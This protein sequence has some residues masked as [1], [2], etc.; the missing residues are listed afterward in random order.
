MGSTSESVVSV[1]PP[2]VRE[3]PCSS[4]PSDL[5]GHVGQLGVLLGKW[6]DVNSH[7]RV[8][9]EQS[10]PSKHPS[11][12]EVFPLPMLPGGLPPEEHIWLQAAIRALNW[13]ACGDLTLGE[14][15]ASRVQESLLTVLR[16]SFR[17]ERLGSHVFDSIPMEDYW[18]SKGVNGYGEEVHSALPFN[19][20][21]IEHSLP[22]REQ[23]GALD[24]VDVASAGIKDFLSDPCKYLKPSPSRTWMKPPRVMVRPEDWGAVAEG[25]VERR[26]CEVIPLSEVIRVEGKPIL[27][28]LF[29]VPKNEEIGGVPVLR[30]IMDLRPINQLFESI[31][32][33]LH[34]LPMLSQL[35][36]L[37]IFP[38]EDVLV[39]SEDIKAMFYIV[40][41]PSE[42]RPLLA[43]GREVP[44]HLRPAGVNEPC[45]LTSRVLPMG[46]INSVSVAQSLHRSIVNRAVDELGISRDK[47]IRRDQSL[48]I[49]ALSYRVYLDNFDSL[50]RTN[51]EAASLLEGSLSPLAAELR[52]VYGK[53]D[54]P[55]NEKKSNRSARQ[56]EMQGGWIDG[57]EGTI[58]PKPDKFARYLRAC[59]Y[60]L[61]SKTSNLKRIQVVAGGLVYLFSYRRCLMS[62][63]NEVW[64]FISSFEG[65]VSVWKAIP[66]VVKK[67]LFCC[68]ALA[69]LSY[70]DLRLPFDALVSASDASE[71][72]GGLS[73]STGVTDMGVQAAGKLVR[74]SYGLACDDVQLLVISLFDGIAACRVALDVLGAQVGAY[75]AV[76]ADPC[77]KRV[78]ESAFA[79]VEFVNTVD[80]VT[81]EIVLSWARRFSRVGVVLISGGP[82]CQG[83][84]GLGA[85]KRGSESASNCRL[86]QEV[87]R[88]RD[89]AEKHF[90]WAKVF[91]LM[92]SVSSMSDGDLASVTR[93]AGILPYELD[94]CGLTPC[95][96]NRLFWFNWQVSSEPGVEIIRPS[97]SEP[98]DYGRIAFLLPVPPDPY[99]T[100]GWSLAG[101]IGQKVPAFVAAQPKAQPGL[102]PAGID[103]CTERDLAYWEADKFRFAPYQY[104]YQHGLVHLKH[105]WRLANA[106][107][108]EA[109]L[110]FPLGYTVECWPKSDRKR[111]P[112]K[113]DNYRLSLLGN[114]SS[115][116][117][118]A[119]LLLH[120]LAPLKLCE[121]Q[122]VNQI[123]KNCQPGQSKHLNSFL[124]RPPW[125]AARQGKADGN[126]AMLVRKL[127]S[128]MS[129]R[130]TDV[131]LQAGTE[132]A[133][134]YD[135]LRTSVPARL[136]KWA[137]ACSWKWKKGGSGEVEH[138]NRLELR[139]VLTSVKWRILKA[140]QT[141]TRYLHLVD[142][143]V[144]LHVINKGRS[145]SRKLRTI[146]KKISAWLLLSANACVLGY[147]D[148]GQNPADAP[149]RRGQKR[150]WGSGR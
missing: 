130:G 12:A 109:M 101:G 40:G 106:Y 112:A 120:L 24:G 21:N 39:S 18:K 121:D 49:S 44:K 28:G 57:R 135:R 54:V 64:Q 46:F 150:K 55:V 132:P 116:P 63:L 51:R 82:P 16:E 124:T 134:S 84:S 66:D 99:L 111:D 14:A 126:D 13:L 77:A 4:L 41:L 98:T 73:V 117:V 100:P 105:G 91:F 96:R 2:E 8:G 97:T 137:T 33:D 86:H 76:E 17:V 70:M 148:T 52:Q 27:G 68:A 88:I 22:K 10:V 59:W 114:S 138:I 89:L 19:W 9:Y 90:S 140:K 95:R 104:K 93:S 75:V 142:S 115:V 32:G 74:G 131:L 141:R 56:G 103:S 102:R 127:S 67:E 60:L 122:T 38:N 146:L 129:T 71:T 36:P 119:Y 108:R 35:F 94:A 144:S 149:S 53:L 61:Q 118:I 48:P 45:V 20:S 87:P 125:T 62:C 50:V 69:P 58:C 123:Q 29:G 72:G 139:A 5:V 26:I 113:H 92:E 110:G 6:L 85:S 42:W 128:L 143:L 25:L 30:L 78:V 107:E 1:S 7:L 11:T 133:R 81:D 31:A 136:W 34:T 47:E 65:N 43:F 3:E 37:E 80:E 79:S 83:G 147:V 23:A 15:P 145:S